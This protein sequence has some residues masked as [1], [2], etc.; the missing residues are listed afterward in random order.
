VTPDD[1]LVDFSVGNQF[2]RNKLL[3][4]YQQ[5]L[6]VAQEAFDEG[7]TIQVNVTADFTDIVNTINTNTADLQAQIDAYTTQ[8]EADITAAEVDF[9]AQIAELQAFPPDLQGFL[10]ALDAQYVQLQADV[11]L[12]ELDVVD[13]EAR[14]TALESFGLPAPQ[15][16][17]VQ[18]PIP[19]NSLPAD[20]STDVTVTT[21]L[22]IDPVTVD[23][24]GVHVATRWEVA[25]DDQ[26]TNVVYDVTS[27][28]DLLNHS[29]TGTNGTEYFWRA[30]TTIEV[31]GAE[32]SVPTSYTTGV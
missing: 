16:G 30:Y 8:F 11:D 10:N 15:A 24:P 1:P 32:G 5:I 12:L 20:A 17:G 21:A 3:T 6:Y 19:T 13:I 7:T 28:V 2:S 29:F 26:F 23:A 14:L 31:P 27:D 18:P 22:T 4:A 9:Q 25:T